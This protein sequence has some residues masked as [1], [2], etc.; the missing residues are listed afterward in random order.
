MRWLMSVRVM[1]VVGKNDG[2]RYDGET[3]MKFMVTKKGQ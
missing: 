3:S 1:I 2:G